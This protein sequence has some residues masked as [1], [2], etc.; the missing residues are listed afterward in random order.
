MIRVSASEAAMR[1]LSSIWFK[2]LANKL[3]KSQL[4]HLS[5]VTKGIQLKQNRN[6]S[7]PVTPNEAFCIGS[8]HVR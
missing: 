2:Y 3:T 8:V 5:C 1:K 4:V 6:N 7:T